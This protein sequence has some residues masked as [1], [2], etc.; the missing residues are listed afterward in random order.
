MAVNATISSIIQ[1]I[2]Q[3]PCPVWGTAMSFRYFWNYLFVRQ[4]EKCRVALLIDLSWRL[5]VS[6]IIGLQPVK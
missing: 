2:R 5:P 1:F 4:A 3:A 6:G